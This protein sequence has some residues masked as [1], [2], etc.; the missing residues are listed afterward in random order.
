MVAAM[1]PAARVLQIATA[2]TLARNGKGRQIRIEAN[3][4]QADVGR[5]VGRSAVT[6]HRWETGANLPS[7]DSAVRWVELLERLAAV[8]A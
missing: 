6:V 8:T 5:A 3:V 4:S 1:E 2:R 7:G